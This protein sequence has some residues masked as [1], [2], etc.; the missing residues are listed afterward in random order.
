MAAGLIGPRF[1]LLVGA[2]SCLLGVVLFVRQIPAIQDK[3]RPIYQRK[4][5]VRQS[6]EGQ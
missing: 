6:D 2:L 4:G 1:T 3:V 5:I